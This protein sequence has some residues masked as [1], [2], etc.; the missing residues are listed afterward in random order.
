MFLT[1]KCEVHHN[2]H[3]NGR[4]RQLPRPRQHLI[5]FVIRYQ[6]A[7]GPLLEVG[8]L[9][10]GIVWEEILNPLYGMRL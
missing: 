1:R 4:F 8:E 5:P 3:R 2:K 10:L 6:A 7:Y 9:I